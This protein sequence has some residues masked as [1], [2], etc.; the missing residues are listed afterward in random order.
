MNPHDL[1]DHRHLK[2]ARLPIPP[3]LH[4]SLAFCDCLIIITHHIRI[5]NKFFLFFSERGEFYF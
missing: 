1:N 2:P 5:V 4:L 3:L